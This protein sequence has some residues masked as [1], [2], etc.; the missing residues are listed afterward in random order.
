MKQCPSAPK[1][2]ERAVRMVFDARD[3]CPPKRDRSMDLARK[4]RQ[5]RK[6]N[7]IRKLTSVFAAQ[8]E[9]CRHHKK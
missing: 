5:R 8:A 3:R 7:E 1:V 6:I 9:L 4:V 2:I